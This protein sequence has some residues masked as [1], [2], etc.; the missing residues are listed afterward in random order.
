M[1]TFWQNDK[2][3]EIYPIYYKG[4]VGQMVIFGEQVTWGRMKPP[5]SAYKA[6]SLFTIVE[7]EEGEN[8]YCILKDTTG[9]L[10]KL[11]GSHYS[12]STRFLYD[13]QEWLSWNRMRE[14]EALSEKNRE[15]ERLEG[16]IALLKDILIN[17]GIRVVTEAQ[18]K[19][20]GLEEL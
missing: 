14:K 7:K 10:I 11:Q 6:P 2:S 18:A 15:I 1:L 19:I 5:L 12:T 4:Q 17:Q 8:G 13:A 3:I 20:L 9:N 16:H